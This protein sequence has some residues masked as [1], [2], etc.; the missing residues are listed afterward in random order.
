MKA[1]NV[2]PMDPSPSRIL[3]RQ[4]EILGSDLDPN[5]FE[6]IVLLSLFHDRK[7]RLNDD[8]TLVM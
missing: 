3:R 1:F 7:V 8:L 4:G 6:E 2:E 5:S